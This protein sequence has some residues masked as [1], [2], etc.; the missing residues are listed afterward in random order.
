MVLVDTDILIDVSR[1]DESASD[2]LDELSANA[3]PAISAVT[4]MELITGCRNSEEVSKLEISLKPFPCLHIDQNIS[5]LAITLLSRYRLS[6]GLQIADSLIAATALTYE[7]AL[8]S[9]NQRHFRYISGI[10][11]LNYP[12]DANYK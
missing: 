12:K 11:L 6:H 9:K 4:Y 3:T 8:V 10:D 2:F 7:I 1:R 5:A